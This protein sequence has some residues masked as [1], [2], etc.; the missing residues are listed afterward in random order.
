MSTPGVPPQPHILSV[1][2]L[3]T[4]EVVDGESLGLKCAW[5]HVFWQTGEWAVD[6]VVGGKDGEQTY[7]REL[8]SPLTWGGMSCVCFGC[9]GVGRAGWAE[10]RDPC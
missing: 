7:Q 8:L 5:G 2:F 10:L 6:G 3:P 9:V 4:A 1:N